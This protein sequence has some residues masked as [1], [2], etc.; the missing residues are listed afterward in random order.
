MEIND[1]VLQYWHGGF[2]NIL[3]LPAVAQMSFITLMN[4]QELVKLGRAGFTDRHVANQN[5]IVAGNT[6]IPVCTES[7]CIST[8]CILLYLMSRANSLICWHL[9][10]SDSVI[11]EFR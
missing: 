5:L 11:K 6:G 4:F 3:E 10:H 1:P 7:Q 9:S 2:F 8:S